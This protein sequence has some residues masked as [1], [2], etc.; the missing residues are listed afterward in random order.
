[1]IRP[2]RQTQDTVTFR[3]V[4]FDALLEELEDARDA[5]AARRAERKRRAGKAEYVPA[6][7]VAR[8]AAGEHPVRVWREHR[9]LSLSALA[10]A[11]DV[12]LGYLSEIET[13]KKPGSLRALRAIA[14][15]L[16]LSLDE[17][18]AWLR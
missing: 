18:A 11:S 14:R 2:L 10:R 7:I 5:A 17:L 8:L 15:A 4:D 6:A 1:M 3:R 13:E 16:N 9:G 12:K